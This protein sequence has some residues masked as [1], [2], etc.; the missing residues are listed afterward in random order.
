[1]KKSDFAMIILIASVSVMVA[2]GVVSAI[3]VLKAPSK[4][5]NVQTIKKYTAE[6]VEPDSKTFNSDA[7]NPTVMVTIGGGSAASQ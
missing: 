4:P 1:M 6:V 3:P 7:I 5:V 2:Y